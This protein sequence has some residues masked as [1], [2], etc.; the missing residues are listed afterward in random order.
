MKANHRQLIKS[1]HNL[2]SEH[3][4]IQ[5]PITI[6][7]LNTQ[8]YIQTLNTMK[9]S[10]FH[11]FFPKEQE[12]GFKQI[13]NQKNLIQVLPAGC[14]KPDLKTHY[15]IKIVWKHSPDPMQTAGTQACHKNY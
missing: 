7:F 8:I 9:N 15:G 10:L 12:T 13:R 2:F 5:N 6:Y 14:E 3:A 4:N 1:N 11:K